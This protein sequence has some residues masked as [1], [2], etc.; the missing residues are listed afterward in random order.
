MP[1]AAGD[2]SADA[3]S[4]GLPPSELARINP[5]NQIDVSDAMPSERPRKMSEKPIEVIALRA[6]YYAPN[7]IPGGAK[8][9]I[10]SFKHL[11][12]W[13]KCVDPQMQK[14]HVENMKKRKEASRNRH[15][16]DSA[17]E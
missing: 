11:G 8:F 4:I 17:G 2:V 16:I 15:K 3:V 9:T 13:M 6:G 10:A 5:S 1:E 7:R 12:S 14:L